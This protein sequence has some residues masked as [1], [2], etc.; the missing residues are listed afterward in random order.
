MP[1]Y[2]PGFSERV[3]E[4]GFNSEY[5]SANRALLAAAPHVPTQ[6][7]EKALGY[8]VAFEITKHGGAVHSVAL[9]HKTCRYVD[10]A[11]GSNRRFWDAAG[12]AYFAFRLNT[13]QFNV[14]ES[15]ASSDLEG[16]EFQYCAPLFSKRCDMDHHYLANTVLTHS[17]WI[18]PRGVGPITDDDTHTIVFNSTGTQ[19]F[20]FSD[21]ARSLTVLTP[22]T[23]PI[24]DRQPETKRP[25]LLNLYETVYGALSRIEVP[26]RGRRVRNEFPQ[27]RQLPRFDK[28]QDE[29]GVIKALSRLLS[30]YLG[31]S[32]LVEVRQ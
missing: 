19:A 23:G 14:I 21:D 25:D 1:V 5:A 28:T 10:A 6:N 31:I 27:W 29:A 13:D 15:V 16:V 7:E 17:V 20:L 24:P 9:Q 12:G 22:R 18:N 8:D 3:F 32:W 11:K 30:E 2:P 26:R 4:F